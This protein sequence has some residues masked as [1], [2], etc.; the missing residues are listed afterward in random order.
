MTMYLSRL[1]LNPRH[2]DTRRWLGDCHALHRAI[3]GA[4]PQAASEQAR[5][6][7]GI[8]YRVEQARGEI[9]ILVQSA[10]EPVWA[11]ETPA[12]QEIAG[13]APLDALE[14]LLVPG[15]R[16]R[17]RL[18][19]NPTRRVHQR[20]TMSEDREHGRNWVEETKWVGKRVPLRREEDRLAWLARQGERC[21]FRLLESRL[22]P[23]GRDVAL[24]RADIDAKLQGDH[25]DIFDDPERDKKKIRIETARFE[26]VLEVTDAELLRAALQNGIGPGKAF[27]CGLLSLAP[28][29]RQ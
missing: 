2:R 23:I 25:P 8:L 3:M 17:F 28:V 7:L 1:T 21:G 24:A 20:A 15:A 26:G 18:T 11:F 5:Q 6:E 16:F 4:F 12:V 10:V 22:E 13:P 29:R 27:G 9:R 19:A 14:T